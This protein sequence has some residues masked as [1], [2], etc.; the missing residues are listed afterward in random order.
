MTGNLGRDAACAG[1]LLRWAV[2]RDKKLLRLQNEIA[3]YEL[4]I[5]DELGFVPLSKTGGFRVQ[6][7]CRL[8]IEP[9]IKHLRDSNRAFLP[10]RAAGGQWDAK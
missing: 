10:L 9:L 5:V 6:L 2:W 3:S 8:Q 4:F 7:S 1:P